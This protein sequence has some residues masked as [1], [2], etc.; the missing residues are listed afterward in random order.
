M[1]WKITWNGK[2]RTYHLWARA[3]DDAG[4][5]QPDTVPFNKN[6]YMF[7]AVV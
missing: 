5:I 3:L 1:R 4:N 7:W 2:P 6:G